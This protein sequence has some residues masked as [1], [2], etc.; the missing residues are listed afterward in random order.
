MQPHRPAVEAVGEAQRVDVRILLLYPDRPAVQEVR[1]L[2]L[3]LRD[4]PVR[5]DR[6]RSARQIAAGKDAVG[7]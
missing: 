6:E 2:E 1:L 3:A 5:R 4:R 7:L